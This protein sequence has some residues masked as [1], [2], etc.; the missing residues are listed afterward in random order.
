M[1]PKRLTEQGL[2]DVDGGAGG[3]LGKANDLKAE[4]DERCS[5]EKF[6][7]KRG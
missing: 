5:Y 2:G 4:R 3:C 7:A 1:A 6:W